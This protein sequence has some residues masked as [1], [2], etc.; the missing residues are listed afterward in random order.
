M[1]GKIINFKEVK[2]NYEVKKVINKLKKTYYDVEIDY[3][4]LPEVMIL[5]FYKD[6]YKRER[7]IPYFE[8]EQIGVEQILKYYTNRFI[9]EIYEKKEKE[10]DEEE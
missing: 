9:N 2:L 4:Y 5:L 8:L 3:Y 1:S 10:I 7:A 6:I